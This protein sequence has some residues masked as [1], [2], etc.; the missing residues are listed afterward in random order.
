[1]AKSGKLFFG[2]VIGGMVGAATALLLAPKT[3]RETREELWKS[4]DEA[5]QFLRDQSEEAVRKTGEGAETSDKWIELRE[6]QPTADANE[7]WEKESMVEIGGA[8]N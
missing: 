2:A 6:E 7:S 3:G 8:R 4:L 1:M 5:R